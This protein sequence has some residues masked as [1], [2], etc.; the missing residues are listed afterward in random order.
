MSSR[1]RNPH[2]VRHN[3]S[4]H[5]P[6][7]HVVIAAVTD[8]YDDRH[9]WVHRWRQGATAA[10]WRTEA[11]VWHRADAVHSDP[12][13]LWRAVDS[14][15]R[16]RSRTVVW[17]HDL[18]YHV[19]VTDAL[20]E[21]DALGWCY[22]A[23]NDVVK[24]GWQTW[25]RGDRTLVLVD[26]QSVWPRR[27]HEI[28]TALNSTGLSRGPAAE[29]HIRRGGPVLHYADILTRA[30]LWYLAW[31][32]SEGMGTWQPTGAG[33]S[34]AA[35]RHRFMTYAPH[36]HAETEVLAAERRAMWTGRCEAWAHGRDESAPVYEWDMEAAYCRIAAA[37]SLPVRLI[38]EGAENGGAQLR[39]GNRNQRTLSL[40]T[41]RAD[42][43]ILPGFSGGHILWPT[44][45]FDTVLWDNEVV[46]ARGAGIEVEA[47]RSWRYVSAPA[48]QRWGEWVLG[49]ITA[50]GGQTHPLERMVLKHWSR[51]L[52]GRLSL[53]YQRWEPFAVSETHDWRRIDGIDAE[54]GER[55]DLLWVGGVL[56]RSG[57][58]AEAPDSLP[59]M[60]G[61]IMAECRVWLWRVMLAAGLENVLYVDT[62][63]VVVT[64]RGHAR[65]LASDALRTATGLRLKGRH[66]GYDIRG[67]R[68]A[69]FGGMPKV[70]GVP[71]DAVRTGPD[72]ARGAV[73]ESLPVAL[74]GGRVDSVWIHDRTWHLKG[75]DRRR[76]HL[77]GGRTTAVEL[78]GGPGQP[79]QTA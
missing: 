18:G 60:T 54:T 40:C 67:P 19:R 27:L 44:G 1:S 55:F 3:R 71:T 2:R 11:G 7:R 13:S 49:K 24:S 28:R 26:T 31:L 59:M 64:G 34:W 74:A 42:V 68:Q 4:S 48:L 23:G 41:V 39:G 22:R 76:V 62:D 57:G 16:R 53:R 30:V 29:D 58:V 47:H 77:P 12:H 43:P 6:A 70:S 35:W 25:T 69:W 38:G 65:L 50:P 5:V 20:R 73:T 33:Q 52:I 79:A 45:T 51:A 56:H 32:E 37:T 72:T 21:L 46:T 17:A 66:R 75:V 61:Y 10:L 36:V 9:A 8:T 63:S 14:H 15:T 78:S